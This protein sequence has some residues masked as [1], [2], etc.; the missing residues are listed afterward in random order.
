M[1]G[2][3]ETA[4]RQPPAGHLAELPGGIAPFETVSE[5]NS[6]ARKAFG[7][8]KPGQKNVY[9]FLVPHRDER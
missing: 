5:D 7:E 8:L 3:V 2:V 9:Q 6:G 4:Y 1:G